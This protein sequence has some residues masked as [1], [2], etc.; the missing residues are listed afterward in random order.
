[1]RGP[2]AAPSTTV[3]RKRCDADEGTHGFA[4]QR[5]EFRELGQHGEGRRRADTGHARQDASAFSPWPFLDQCADVALDPCDLA[6]QA[7]QHPLYALARPWTQVVLEAIGLGR[8]VRDQLAPAHDQIAQFLRGPG[9]HAAGLGTERL[10]I[11]GEHVRVED[12]GLR[13]VR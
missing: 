9:E 11:L 4:A 6:F 8:T 12:V 3:A 7:A 10:A 13:Q 1:M 5:P 2:L